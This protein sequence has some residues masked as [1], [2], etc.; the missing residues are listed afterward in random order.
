MNRACVCMCETSHMS[1]W[2]NE[3]EEVAFV[4]IIP[5]F[6]FNYARL[7]DAMLGSGD[8]MRCDDYDRDDGKKEP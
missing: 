3:W 5:G 4:V 6:L 7:D 2:R 8:A 1:F